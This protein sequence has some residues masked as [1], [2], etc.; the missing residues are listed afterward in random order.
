[1]MT[2]ELTSPHP[3][4]GQFCSA[5]WITHTYLKADFHVIILLAFANVCYQLVLSVSSK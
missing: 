5:S 2:V 1:M 4:L 3:S